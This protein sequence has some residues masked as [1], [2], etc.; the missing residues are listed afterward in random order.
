MRS[1]LLLFALALT[2]AACNNLEDADPAERNTFVKFFEGLYDLSASSIEVIPGG[3]II[4]G[5]EAVVLS[6]TTY[7]RTVLIETDENGNRVGDIHSFGGGTGKSFKPIVNSGTVTGYIVVGDS[8]YIDPQAEQAA[9]VAIASMRILVVNNTFDPSSVKNVYITDKTPLSPSHPVKIDFYGGAVNLSSNGSVIVLGTFKEGLI[10]QQAA[11]EKQLL[12]ALNNNQDSTWFKTYDLLTNTY[13]NARS[14]HYSNGKII[15]AT[16]IADV[17]GDFTSSYIAIPKVSEESVFENFDPFG[18]NTTQLFLPQDIQPARSAAFGYGV[19][20]TYSQATDGSESNLFFLR[21]DTQ[22]NII[23]GSDRYFDGI[24]SFGLGVTDVPKDE[25]SIVDTGETLTSTSDGG[26]VLAG[27]MTTNPAK[28]N[29]G[30]DILL[31]K[32]TGQ[33]DMIWAKTLGG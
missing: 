23:P 22:G 14:V 12:F 16:A 31:V 29:G 7:V 20:G 5:N 17:Q 26:F 15:W 6:D 1:I 13:A 33:G 9:N 11:P 21:V 10:N 30:K 32:V 19:V 27:T 25:S 24:E 3:Y 8:I 28:G 4:L 2:V 18:Q